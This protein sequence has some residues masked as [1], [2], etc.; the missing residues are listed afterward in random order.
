MMPTLTIDPAV[1]FPLAWA[2]AALIA[3]RRLTT[4]RPV[5]GAPTDEHDAHESLRPAA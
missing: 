1:L 3:T 2:V 5:H 4:S